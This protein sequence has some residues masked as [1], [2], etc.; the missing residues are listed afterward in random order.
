MSV[1]DARSTV[2]GVSGEAGR[3]WSQGDDLRRLIGVFAIVVAV[4]AAVADPGSP[5]EVVLGAVA[6]GAL[7][8]WAALP[9]TPL[10][11]VSI[12]VVVAVVLAQRSGGLEPLMFEASLLAFVVGRW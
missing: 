3:L 8:L 5:G 6:A 12:V 9:A 1:D 7:A 2:A 4:V 10:V 11:P